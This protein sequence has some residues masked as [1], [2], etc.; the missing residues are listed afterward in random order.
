MYGDTE[1][2]RGL[3]RTMRDQGV[4]SKLRANTDPAKLHAILT[5]A[6]ASAAA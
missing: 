3:A 6:K 5:E 4:V 1:R 2:I